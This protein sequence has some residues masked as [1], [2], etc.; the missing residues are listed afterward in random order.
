MCGPTPCCPARPGPVA[1]RPGSRPRQLP[2]GRPR[3]R[4]S[5]S[6]VTLHFA[7]PIRGPGGPAPARSR[8][9]EL[10][11]LY[12]IVTVAPLQASWFVFARFVIATVPV[13]S[14]WLFAATEVG[15]EDSRT[16]YQDAWQVGWPTSTVAAAVSTN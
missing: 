6:P 14:A 13:K 8:G 10:V 1:V 16:V 5:A 3:W 4:T 11:A 7:R 2:S 9:Q 15:G 12:V